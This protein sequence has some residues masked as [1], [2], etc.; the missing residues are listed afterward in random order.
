MIL[1]LHTGPKSAP[2]LALFDTTGIAIVRE[3]PSLHPDA[4]P[5]VDHAMIFSAGSDSPILVHE[6]VEEI[7]E[8][9]T[10]SFAMLGARSVSS[11]GSIVS[12]TADALEQSDH[13]FEVEL[14]EEHSYRLEDVREA[15]D[16]AGVDDGD[17]LKEGDAVRALAAE[18]DQL[19]DLVEAIREE[20]GLLEVHDDAEV[21]RELAELKALRAVLAGVKAFEVDYHDVVAR[22]E[23][24][25]DALAAVRGG[26][27]GG[28]L[29]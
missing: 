10:A 13:D 1:A 15:L 22:A 14:W 21:L 6:T 28:A 18:R 16:E 5:Q 12:T 26:Y 9:L 2:K 17:Q 29:S 20:L 24:A 3:Q 7:A 11:P 27:V 25:E 8:L 4:P 23:A 19:R